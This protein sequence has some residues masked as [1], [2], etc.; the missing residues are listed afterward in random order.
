MTDFAPIRVRLAP[1]LDERSV[2]ARLNDADGLVAARLD[3][4]A[5]VIRPRRQPMV[6]GMPVYYSGR[7]EFRGRLTRDDNGQPILSGS[8]QQSDLLVV[9]TVVGG[10]CATFIALIGSAL[11]AS[12]D[13]SGVVVVLFAAVFGVA[14]LGTAVMQG[15][16]STKDEQSIMTAIGEIS[17]DA[18]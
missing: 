14:L 11:I 2:V 8:V 12:G 7:P 4:D 9:F 6:A 13:L 18:S 3:G 1:G 10:V 17:E 16:L 5:L 15:R